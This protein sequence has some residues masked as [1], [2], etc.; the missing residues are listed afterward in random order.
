MSYDTALISDKYNGW[1]N[2]NTWLVN[3]WFEENFN[4]ASNDG[5]LTDIRDS[6]EEHI[7]EIIGVE[8]SGFMGDMVGSFLEDVNWSEIESH[9]VLERKLEEDYVYP[10][11][12]V[13]LTPEDVYSSVA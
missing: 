9:Y 1:T 13:E 5:C 8:R 7:D 3:L 6:V 11:D 4:L 12:E 10:G 2:Y